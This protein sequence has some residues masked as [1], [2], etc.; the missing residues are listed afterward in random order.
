MKH[1]AASKIFPMM[2]DEAVQALAADIRANGLLVPIELCDGMIIDGRHRWTACTIA[3]VKPDTVEVDPEDPVAYVLSLNLHRRHLDETQRAMIAAR[4]KDQFAKQ[5]KERMTRKPESVVKN[6]TQQNGKARDKAGEAV[7]VSGYSVNAATKVIEKGSKQLQDLCDRGE[8]AVSAAAKIADLPKQRQNEL[9]TE[10]KSQPTSIK[11]AVAQAAKHVPKKTQSEWTESEIE[12][13]KLAEQGNA[14]VANK[15]KDRNLIR[16][17][18]ESGIFVP[19]DRGTAFGNPFL[20]GDAPDG[21]GDR[22]TVCKSYKKYL[23]MRPSLQA[24]IPGLTG[25]VL[26]CWCFPLQCHG[27]HLSNEANEN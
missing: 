26:G 17:A 14:V 21:D 8:V 6:S 20:I 2:P 27:N 11:R 24:K 4:A 16:W 7:G 3:G 13:R 10:A 25:K 18:A 9:I 1:H 22:V 23:S 12:R 19:I 15:S 5:A